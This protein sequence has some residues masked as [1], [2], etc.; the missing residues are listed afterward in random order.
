[1]KMMKK[2]INMGLALSFIVSGAFAQSLKDAKVAINQEQYDKA[3][4]ILKNLVEN[5]AKE[6]DNYYYLGDVYL[7]TGYPDS[8]KMIFQKGDLADTK[9][10]INKVGLGSVE[11]LAGNASGAQTLFDEATE[12]LK[13]RDYEEL[14]EVGKA[15]LKGDKPDYNKALE[16]LQKAK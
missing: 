7:A 2:A 4:G 13:K 16:Y 1:M 11:L 10:T 12:K 6:G 5:D 3:K 15:Y 9:N 8:A 14:L